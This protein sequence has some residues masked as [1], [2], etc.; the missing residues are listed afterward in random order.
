MSPALNLKRFPFY[1]DRLDGGEPAPWTLA[2]LEAFAAAHPDDPYAGRAIG[3]SRSEVSLQLEATSEPPVWAAL[4][5]NELSR[6]ARAVARMW[7]RWGVAA[8]ETI[9]FFEY[10]SS[11]LVLLA[12]SGYVGYLRRGAAEILGLA[13]ICNDGVAT[14][15][16][17]MVSIVE[18]VRPSMLILRRELASPFLAALESSGL[19]TRERV[20]WIGLT[21]VEGAPPVSDADRLSSALGVPV[22][23]ILRADAAYMLAGECLKC[24][25]FHLDREYNASE[26]DCGEVAIS[27]KFAKTCPAVNYNI[28]SARLHAG[29]CAIEPKAL[30]I[31]C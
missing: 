29:G 21:A 16:P 27:A 22:H 25:A 11:P 14:M 3:K 24:R 8:G 23:R 28:G 12:S 9:A 1:C 19:A 20:R 4:S 2:D 26:R 15:A 6:W 17:R 31:E 10:G 30:R 13:A 18:Q 7:A 5:A